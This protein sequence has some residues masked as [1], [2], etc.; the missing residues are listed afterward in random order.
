MSDLWLIRKALKWEPNEDIV[1]ISEELDK[2][3]G[4]K[5][6]WNTKQGKLSL[7]YLTN[8]CGAC[9]VKLQAFESLSFD[10]VKSLLAK[11]RANMVLLSTMKETSAIGEIQ[12]MLDEE[13][14]KQ[15]D[16][17]NR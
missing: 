7:E 11:Y 13:V 5:E 3:K 8:D 9:M 14:K 16:M 1:L 4:F 6:F 15:Y 2:K 17:M 10:E 12:D